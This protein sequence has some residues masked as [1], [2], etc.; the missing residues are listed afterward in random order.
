MTAV[1]RRWG[2]LLAGVGVLTGMT[3]AAYLLGIRP[4]SKELARYNVG[5]LFEIVSQQQPEYLFLLG[6]CLVAA[7]FLI[8][9]YWV[10]LVL[11]TLIAFAWVIYYETVSVWLLG[12]SGARSWQ[13]K[14]AC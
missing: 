4:S 5:R 3:M 2:Y 11:V 7:S 6:I 10:P 8:K 12:R 1:R 14:T 9:R 13:S